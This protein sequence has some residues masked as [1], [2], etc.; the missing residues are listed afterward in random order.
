MKIYTRTG[1]AGLT[2]LYGGGRVSKNDLRIAAYGSIDELNACLG[3]CRTTDLPDEVDSLLGRLQ[4]EMFALGAE[5]ASPDGAAPGSIF[6]DEADIASAEAAI[7]HFDAKL[8]PLKTFVLP[9]GSAASAALHVARAVCRRAER[10][11]VALAQSSEV[12]PAAL[13]YLNRVSD[14]LFVLARHA[15]VFAG[16]P[17]VQWVKK[18]G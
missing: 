7:D 13:V 3:L 18:D 10:D 15:N 17:D 1:D 11:V 14:L 5:L 2:G 12:R 6:L 16:I 8:T 4:H 9:G